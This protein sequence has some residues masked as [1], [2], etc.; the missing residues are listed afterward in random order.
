MAIFK[1]GKYYWFEFQ[2]DGKRIRR[3]TRV[4]NQNDARN[5]ESAYRTA[6]AKGEAG[7]E[8][9][10]AAPT[11]KTFEEQF[12]AWI[13]ETKENVRTRDFYKV[14]YSRLVSYTPLGGARLD[15]IDEPLLE[16]FK[17]K[18]LADK[19]SKTTVNR[20]LATLRKALRY[21]ALKLKMFDRLPVVSMF[22]DER[23]REYIFTPTDY[24]NWLALAP[25]P[26]RSA[27]ILARNLGICRNEMLTLQR[28]CITL[29]DESDDN[30][31]FGTLEIKRGLKRKERR[32]TLPVSHEVRTAL[33]SLLATSKCEFVFTAIESPTEPL[34]AW[35]LEGQLQRTRKTLNL[36]PDAGLHTL[37]HTFLTEMGR[38]TDTF[39]LQKIAG[40]AR[41]TTTTRYVHPQQDAITDAFAAREFKVPTKVPTV[42]R[43]SE[44]RPVY[45]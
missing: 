26:L 22:P 8:R 1:R 40:H 18:M 11:L 30:G 13:D 2:F 33:V 41:I 27:S 14:S 21:A 25:E 35:T 9:K 36:D 38:K 24:S 44:K 15:R 12:C 31:M 3:P 5:I 16:K 10:A 29:A 43:S 42:R 45:N 20:Y 23:Q 28:D 39:T 19:L 6:L 34:S 32:R 7:I 37:R 4:R 17:S